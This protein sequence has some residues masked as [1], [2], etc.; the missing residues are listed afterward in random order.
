M[1]DNAPIGA[2]WNRRISAVRQDLSPGLNAALEP[3]L[4]RFAVTPRPGKRQPPARRTNFDHRHVP[5]RLPDAWFVPFFEHL[6]VAS[7]RQLRRAAA[8]G[9]V[10]LVEGGTYARARHLLGMPDTLTAGTSKLTAW[11]RDNADAFTSALNDL[12]DH[13]DAI[14]N[15]VDYGNRRQQLANWSIPTEQWAITTHE[16]SMPSTR[17]RRALHWGDNADVASAPVASAAGEA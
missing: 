10:R 9:L 8:I 1:A 2:A 6:S 14:P 3:I 17:N 15:L 4:S 12:A 16:Q 11:L 7:S 5:Q 13:L